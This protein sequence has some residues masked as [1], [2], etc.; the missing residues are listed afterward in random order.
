MAITLSLAE[1]RSRLE[2]AREALDGLDEVLHEAVG[3]ELPELTTLVDDLAARAGGARALFTAEASRRGE[4]STTTRAWVRQHA[5]SQQ[6]GGAAHLA[7]LVGMV[8]KATSSLDGTTSLDPESPLGIVWAAV[9]TGREGAL[10]ADESGECD[11]MGEMWASGDGVDRDAEAT[12]ITPGLGLAVISEMRALKRRLRPE[13]VPTVTRALVALGRE[14]GAAHMRRM[15]P[16]LLA[17][18]GLEGELD[19]EH[20]RLRPGAFLS[21]PEVES[22][23]L[24]FYRMA[25]TPE[26]AAT[27]E[28]VI[29]P[30]AK[31]QPNPETG[32][33]D[34]RPAGQR[35]AEA[36]ID[37]CRRAAGVVSEDDAHS[38][39]GA[40][41]SWAAVHVAMTLEELRR[42]T[43]CVPAVPGSA[44]S[45]PSPTAEPFRH[46]VAMG[47]TADGVILSPEMLRRI[48]CGAD[49]IP[50]VLGSEGELLDQGRAIRTFNRAQRRRLLKRDRH[51][52]FPGC[53][54]P[55][56]W[57]HAHHVKHWFD[58]GDSDHRNGALLCQRHHT[59]VHQRRLWAEVLDRPDAHGRYVVWDLTLG[60]YDRALEAERLEWATPPTPPI[61]LSEERI[62]EL[63]R[64]CA[65][66]EATRAALRW[67]EDERAREEEVWRCCSDPACI[68]QLSVDEIEERERAGLLQPAGAA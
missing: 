9:T 64:R 37:V 20:E 16:L 55:A 17:T 62:V 22:G 35:R 34:H 54:M 33:R 27:L 57:S 36:L 13:A 65:D 19:D 4:F 66:P 48:A 58:G 51:C 68:C 61:P 41:G 30:L 18:Y 53:D 25:L 26:Q 7:Q 49:L 42:L 31:P 32:D 50:H 28:A 21:S 23:D 52:T 46:G 10:S 40:A 1:R 43:G 24:T 12:P 15:R 2:A 60:S 44:F 8:E 63:L 29:G 3:E 11:E 38:A 59:I 14:W 56:N 39:E 47:S 6:Q 5:P 67:L 45:V